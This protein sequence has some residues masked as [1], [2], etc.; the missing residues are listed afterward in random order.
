MSDESEKRP[1][2]EGPVK[3]ASGPWGLEEGW[4]TEDPSAASTGTWSWR[5]AGS[6]GSTAT[7]PAA[8]GLRTESMIDA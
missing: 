5:Q 7:A 8:S 1:R 4:W 2:V 3:V 6:T